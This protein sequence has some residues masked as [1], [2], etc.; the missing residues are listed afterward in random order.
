MEIGQRIKEVRKAVGITQVKF[1]N[2]IAVV[3]SYISEVENGVRQANERA[4]RLI[5]GEFNVSDTWLRTGRGPM[6]NEDISAV[7]S[8]AMGIL[9]SLDEHAQKGAL[10]MLA[11][12]A[13][14][15]R[16]KR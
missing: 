5:I 10:K 2:R 11:A 3:P 13:E 1:A 12:L 7:L 15:S 14:V 4:I 6:F 8:E 9:K 16:G